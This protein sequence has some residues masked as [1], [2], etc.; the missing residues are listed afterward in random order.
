MAI[1]YTSQYPPAQSDT[2]VKATT[3]YGTGAWAYFA[4]DP[5]LLLTGPRA[6]NS[7]M[8]ESLVCTNQRF[9]IDL[10]SAKIIKRIYY[11]NFHHSG[12]LTNRGVNNFTF[13]GSNTGAGTFDDLVYGNDEGW[14]ELTVA[15]NTLDEHTAS[16]VAD[17][18]YIIVTN[19]T[20]YRYY[21]FKFADVHGSSYMGVRRVELQIR[22]ALQ[23]AESFSIVDSWIAG[24]SLAEAF[25]VADSLVK[26]GIEQLAEALSVVDSWVARI[27]Q[28]EAFSIADTLVKSGVEQ[29]AEAFSVADTLVLSA[30]KAFAETLS[31]VMY[32]WRKLKCA[33]LAWTKKDNPVTTWTKKD[34]PTTDWTKKD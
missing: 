13:W 19:S 9:H 2:Y 5:A 21:G 26:N 16:D 10:G 15:Q 31:F 12:G 34:D 18:K 24:I 4:T 6:D 8:A 22:D 27:A 32:N 17:P 20:A 25:S 14:T 33:A 3:K 11:E 7:W 30:K 1:T 23:L 28:S 29:I